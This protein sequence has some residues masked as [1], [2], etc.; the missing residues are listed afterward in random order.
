MRSFIERYPELVVDNPGGKSD[1]L[2]ESVL[3][4]SQLALRIFE[5]QHTSIVLG[6]NQNPYTE[7]FIEH[8]QKDM[9][10]LYRR[11]S[12]GG[13]VV[14]SVGT[15]VVAVR[16]RQQQLPIEQ[17]FAL[18]N[19]A[20]CTAIMQASGQQA[21]CCGHGD[22]ACENAD[23]ALR[24]VLGASLRQTKDAVY[25]LGV[26]LVEDCTAAMDRYLRFPSKQPDYRADRSHGAFCTHLAHFGVHSPTFMEVL[27][28][29]YAEQLASYL[30]H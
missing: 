15:V 29:V 25:Y 20:S 16:L 6:R 2:G 13:T 4:H 30:L 12:G 19:K 11:V 17:Y 22:L 10:P 5:P 1:P 3:D 18:L 23:G 14:L 7:I 8:A 24:K 28:T 9:I 27:Q 26:F 21:R